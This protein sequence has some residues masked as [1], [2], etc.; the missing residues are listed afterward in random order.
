M[1]S[2]HSVVTICSVPSTRAR[3][4][5]QLDV[6]IVKDVQGWSSKIAYFAYKYSSRCASRSICFKETMTKGQYRVDLVAICRVV[7]VTRVACFRLLGLK[8]DP[9]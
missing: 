3:V 6:G 8:R 4:C 1:E 5:A 2:T 7:H 9:T